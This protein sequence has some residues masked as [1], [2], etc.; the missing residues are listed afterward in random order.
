[1]VLKQEIEMKTNTEQHEQDYNKLVELLN[2][3]NK[4]TFIRK[5]KEQRGQP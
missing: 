5:V 1:M 2:E 3:E 4:E